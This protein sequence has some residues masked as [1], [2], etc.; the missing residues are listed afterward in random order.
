MCGRYVSTASPE[1]LAERFDAQQL[2]TG[3]LGERYNVAPSQPVYVV[4]ERDGDRSLDTMRWGFVPAWAQSVT[5]RTPINARIET[6]ARSRMFRTSFQHRRCLLP[7]DGFYEWQATAAQ[8]PSGRKPAKQPWYI[9]PADDDV[10]AF[11]G[12]WTA[13]RDPNV[14]ADHPP[15]ISC[16]MLTTEANGL[17]AKIHHRMPLMLPSSVWDRWLAGD[18]DARELQAT[19][20]AL[21]P[22]RLDAYQVTTRVNRPSNEGPAL[23]DPLPANVADSAAVPAAADDIEAEDAGRGGAAEG[24]EGSWVTL[25]LEGIGE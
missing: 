8:L 22:P 10:F 4:R 19:I 11:A 21:A 18:A 14:D 17:M 1:A 15:V 7:A 23:L 24:S 16:A 20:G 3:S 12:I 25:R 9:T 5:G 2:D 6:V 13:W